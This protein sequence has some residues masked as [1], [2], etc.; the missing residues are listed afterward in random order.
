MNRIPAIALL[1]LVLATPFS[2]APV[3]GADD[4]KALEAAMWQ[5]WAK[6]DLATFE[7][8]LTDDH[9]H[10]A[11]NGLIAGKKENLAAMKEPCEVRSWKL[12]DIRVVP[13]GSDA[14]LLGYEAN[15]DATCDGEKLPS[16]IYV[17]VV[18]KKVGG[19]WM[20]ASYHETGAAH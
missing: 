18:W 7:E 10:V 13:L 11:A 3:L 16:H 4:V 15:Q 8:R 5:A 2:A 20:N 19:K 6:H 1:T 12:G 17:T 9:I 14:A